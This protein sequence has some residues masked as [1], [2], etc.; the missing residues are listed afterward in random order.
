MIQAEEG[1]HLR[2]KLQ[3]LVSYMNANELG[4][5]FASTCNHIIVVC[6]AWLLKEQIIVSGVPQG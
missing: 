2:E 3:Y 6:N 5:C 1:L 4:T